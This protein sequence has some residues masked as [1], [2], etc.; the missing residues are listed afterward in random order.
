MRSRWR[1]SVS[2]VLSSAAN[3]WRLALSREIN[4]ILYPALAKRRLVA[5]NNQL[6]IVGEVVTATYAEA[7]PVPEEFPRPATTKM[8]RAVD[9]TAVMQPHST[10]HHSHHILWK[11]GNSSSSSSQSAGSSLRAL[12]SAQS[13]G[14]KR[15]KKSLMWQI[16][17]RDLIWPGPCASGITSQ[18]SPSDDPHH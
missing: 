17:P 6:C 12:R 11:C 10:M 14:D 1:T 9:M 7:P 18:H 5:A 15:G 16:S 13:V 4:A 8:G 2:P 3:L